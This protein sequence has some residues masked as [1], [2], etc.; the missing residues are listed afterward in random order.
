MLVSPMSGNP[1]WRCTPV[2]NPRI[3]TE[4]LKMLAEREKLIFADV[5]RTW[6]FVI[7]RK[8]FF[9]LIGNGANHPNDFGHSLYARTILAALHRP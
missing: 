9:S 2:E 1:E 6:N 5:F 7:E 4:H 3:F 8:E